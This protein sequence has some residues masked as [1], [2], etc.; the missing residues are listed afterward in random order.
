MSDAQRQFASQMFVSQVDPKAT[1]PQLGA[2]QRATAAAVMA[3]FFDGS[4]LPSPSD[5]FELLRVDTRDED[6]KTDMAI[7]FRAVATLGVSLYNMGLRDVNTRDNL[8]CI[9]PT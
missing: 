4:P 6:I 1:G 8:R 9:T 3:P 7:I 5:M 2:V